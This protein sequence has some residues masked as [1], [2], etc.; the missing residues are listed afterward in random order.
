MNKLTRK[1]K[2]SLHNEK[3]I[4]ITSILNFS[5]AL[6]ILFFKYISKNKLVITITELKQIIKLIGIFTTK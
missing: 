4:K 5:S 3:I 2:K 6:E 1:Y